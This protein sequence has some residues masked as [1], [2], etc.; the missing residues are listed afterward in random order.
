MRLFIFSSFIFLVTII[1]S[2]AGVPFKNTPEEEFDLDYKIVFSLPSDDYNPYP[3][4]IR[5][6]PF[7]KIPRGF[8]TDAH[9][10]EVNGKSCIILSNFPQ[11]FENFNFQ[12]SGSRDRYGATITKSNTVKILN[13]SNGK[14]EVLLKGDPLNTSLSW[15][16][17]HLKKEH[18]R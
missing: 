16:Y 15:L 3:I 18:N 10:L 11:G 8:A 12:C 17:K 4:T 5:E 7:E 1:Q 14:K 2:F 13:I 6:M 9:L